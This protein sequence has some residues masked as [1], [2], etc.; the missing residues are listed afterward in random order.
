MWCPMRAHGI[1]KHTSVEYSPP[2][3]ALHESGASRTYTEFD[4][5]ERAEQFGGRF[6]A[7]SGMLLTV[8]ETVGRERSQCRHK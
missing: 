3:K 8:D 7:D 6:V 4:P 1:L 2:P 5:S